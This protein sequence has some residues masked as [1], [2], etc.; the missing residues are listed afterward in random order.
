MAFCEL[1][2]ACCFI[3][4]YVFARHLYILI[5]KVTG[6]FAVP[7]EVTTCLLT[8]SCVLMETS[9]VKSWANQTHNGLFVS[10]VARVR[11]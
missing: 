3:S 5:I 1:I 7:F 4:N 8:Q 2:T 10:A 6:C 9:M 11:Q